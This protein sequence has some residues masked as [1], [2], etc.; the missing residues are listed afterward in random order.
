MRDLEI[1][2][3]SSLARSGIVV[4]CTLKSL[5]VRMVFGWAGPSSS[6][7]CNHIGLWTTPLIPGFRNQWH[8]DFCD[9]EASL[10]CIVRSRKSG[11]VHG[12]YSS[13][14]KRKIGEI[15]RWL[16]WAGMCM[17]SGQQHEKIPI[18]SDGDYRVGTFFFFWMEPK[19]GVNPKGWDRC[20]LHTFNPSPLWEGTSR[21]VPMSPSSDLSSVWLTHSTVHTEKLCLRR[22]EEKT[23]KERKANKKLSFIWPGFH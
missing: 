18:S 5:T 23:K 12:P 4:V 3:G 8:V 22:K 17:S 11:H 7:T 16:Q 1:K 13:L 14:K 10:V 15:K 6:R 20:L 19:R 9:Q 2:G 21:W